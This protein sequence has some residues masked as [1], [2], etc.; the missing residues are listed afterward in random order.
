MYRTLIAVV[1]AVIIGAL[2]VQ[3]QRRVT[4]V[5]P[6][7]PGAAPVIPDVKKPIDPSRDRK[8]VV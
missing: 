4:P 8:S 7:D 5:V 6:R 2:S 3:A 1:A